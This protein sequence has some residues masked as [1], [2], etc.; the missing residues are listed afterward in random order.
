M[1]TNL[2][3]EMGSTKGVG[4]LVLDGPVEPSWAETLHSTLDDSR[5]LSLPSGEI[6]NIE[7]GTSII[8]EAGD[9]SQVRVT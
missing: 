2:H 9:L 7:R 8:F 3:R 6:I 4:W 5:R 1:N